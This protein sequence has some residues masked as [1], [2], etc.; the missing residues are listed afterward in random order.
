MS[1]DFSSLLLSFVPLFVAT[2]VF[3]VIP[4]F[5]SLA[6]RLKKTKHDKLVTEATIGAL[7]IAIVFLFGG[8]NFSIPWH[9]RK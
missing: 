3:G 5:L 4:I 2:D 6:E 9:N 8:C 1:I 7:A